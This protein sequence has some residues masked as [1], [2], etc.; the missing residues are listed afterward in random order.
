MGVVRKIFR[1]FV[2]FVEVHLP[3]VV[4]VMLFLAFLTNVFCRYIIKNPQNW[5]FELSV[6]AFV[7]VG[8]LGACTAYRREDHVVFDLLYTRLDSKGQNIL[9]IIS[10]V[11]VIVFFAIALPGSVRYLVRL[12]AVTSI[13][14]IPLRFIFLPYPIL[15]M[16]MIL[17]SANRLVLDI[18]AFRNG[19]YVQS[20]NTEDQDEVI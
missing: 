2:D 18:R 4:F 5:T 16:S 8:L 15:L 13:M 6:N 1:W 7:V 10:S 12:P 9:R 20:Y 19:T 14:R 3:I 17:R 11:V